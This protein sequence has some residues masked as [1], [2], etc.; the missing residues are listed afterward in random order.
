VLLVDYGAFNLNISKFLKRAGIKTFYYIPPQ[1]WASRKWRLKTMR[2]TIDK[3][4]GIFPFE[5]KL[6]EG[7]DFHFC[8]H[9]LVAQLPPA[10][11]REEFF[12]RHGL[13]PDKKLVSIFPGSR[14]FELKHLMKLFLKSACELQKRHLDLQFCVSQAPNL[15]NFPD[16]PFKVIKGE[17]HALLSVSDSLILASGTVALEAALYQTPMLIA[18]KGPL[19]FYLIYLMVVCTKFVSLPNIITGKLIVPELLQYGAGVNEIVKTTEELLYNENYRAEHIAQ[20]GDVRALLS[21]KNCAKEVA[22]QIN[23]SL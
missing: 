2:K 4:L 10:A 9:P 19:L 18:Y 11:D 17:N 21:D 5:E 7:M 16:V 1:I 12:K 15:K 20:L 8:G 13:D 6:Y 22:E 23:N 14:V 3:I